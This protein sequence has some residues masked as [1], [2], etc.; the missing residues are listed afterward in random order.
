VAFA[1]T[2]EDLG[3]RMPNQRPNDDQE[4]M[5]DDDVVMVAERI[6]KFLSNGNGRKGS[7]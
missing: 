7:S 4:R 3:G 1:A 5:T 6:K 2:F